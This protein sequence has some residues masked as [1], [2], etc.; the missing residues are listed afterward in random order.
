MTIKQMRVDSNPAIRVAHAAELAEHF[1]ALDEWLAKGGYLPTRWAPPGERV[2]PPR[3]PRRKQPLLVAD[4]VSKVL[5]QVGFE[6]PGGIKQTKAEVWFWATEARAADLVDR[7]RLTWPDHTVAAE[8]IRPDRWATKV[9]RRIEE[10][11]S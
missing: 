6:P 7:L 2:Q 5:E 1:E 3:K 11:V 9:S 4:D 10:K 8:Y